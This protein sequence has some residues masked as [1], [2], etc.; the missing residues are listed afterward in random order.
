MKKLRSFIRF[1]LLG[2][3]G[4]LF[5]ACE[6]EAPEAPAPCVIEG[7]DGG[8]TTLADGGHIHPDSPVPTEYRV[9]KSPYGYDDPALA[10][11]GWGLYVTHC[12][13]CH[14]LDGHGHGP[15]APGLCPPPVDLNE[16]NRLHDDPYLYWRVHD[17]GARSEF[18]TA[19]PAYGDTLGE[20][21][22]WRL[23]TTIRWR[24]ID[25]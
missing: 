13:Q 16:A 6:P 18:L 8:V 22:I 7:L 12:A 19:M 14:G 15:D 25:F 1:W 11:L 4:L 5:A 24:F 2:S 21:G 20:E 3:L 10:S 9:L 17:G 23:I